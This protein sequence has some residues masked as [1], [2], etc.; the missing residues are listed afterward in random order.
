MGT[1]YIITVC[2]GLTLARCQVPTKAAVTPL[3]NWT[4]ERKY[5]ERLMGRAEARERSLTSYRHRQN[6]LDLGKMNII[7]YQSNQGRIIRNKTKSSNTF[8]PHLP[9]SRAQLHSG[10]FTYPPQQHRG[11]GNGGWCQ[12]ITHCLCCSFLL[13]GRTPHTLPLLQHVVP[14]MGDSPP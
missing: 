3:L 2:D 10:F 8:P 1:A 12:F 13:R 11:M 4:G 5:N 14:P 6:R 7:Y 9:S